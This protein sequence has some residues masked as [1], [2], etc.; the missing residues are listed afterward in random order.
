MLFVAFGNDGEVTDY[1]PDTIAWLDSVLSNPFYSNLNKILFG[2]VPAVPI[3]GRTSQGRAAILALAYRHRALAIFSGHSH[4][5]AT[6][7][8]SDGMTSQRLTD[9]TKSNLTPKSGLLQ[10]EGGSLGYGDAEFALIKVYKDRIE[11]SRHSVEGL[12]IGWRSEGQK[13]T[14]SERSFVLG[15]LDL[16][17]DRAFADTEGQEEPTPA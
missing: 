8:S 10:I 11:Y 14:E 9:E 2:H 15:G 1:S 6:H 16:K 3:D 4:R 17:L 13:G 5:V 12:R 7:L